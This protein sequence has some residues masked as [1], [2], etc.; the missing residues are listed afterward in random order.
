MDSITYLFVPLVAVSSPSYFLKVV[1]KLICVQYQFGK[2]PQVLANF[3]KKDK[4]IGLSEWESELLHLVRGFAFTQIQL[5]FYFH[6][7]ILT[8]KILSTLKENKLFTF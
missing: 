7:M 1:Y 2:E 8:E 6:L 5:Q 4:R 3:K